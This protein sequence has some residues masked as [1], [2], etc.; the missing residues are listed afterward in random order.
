MFALLFAVALETVKFQAGQQELAYLHAPG[1]SAVLVVLPSQPESA[2]AEMKNWAPIAASR[3]WR[4]IMPQFP[5]A[6]DPGVKNLDAMV[7]DLRKRYSL[8]RT[9]VYLA[10][11]GA[12]SA[13][14]FYAAARAPYLWT[15]AMA[16]GGSPMPAIDSDRLFAANTLNTPVGWALTPEERTASAAIRQRLTTAGYNLT[17]LEAPTIGQVLDF[18]ARNTITGFPGKIDCETGN[19]AMAQCYWVRLTAFDPAL[20]NDAIRSSRVNPDLPASLDLGGFGYQPTAPGPGVLVEWLPPNYTGALRLKDRIVALSGKPVVDG[21]HYVELMKEVKEERPVS[22]TVER[23]TGKEKERFRLTTRY[24]LRQREEVITARV[25][26][27]FVPESREIVII[28]RAVA[29]LELTI[30]EGWAPSTVNWNGNQ[31]A[32]PQSP[33][34]LVLSLKEPGASRPCASQ[35]SP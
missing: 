33:G 8:A 18:L 28:S 35:V 17:V 4:L 2:E 25:Q 5:S 1:E 26:A 24:Q 32:S 29:A 16:I 21:G 3:K 27:E 23:V 9:P 13:A 7:A 10:G 30:P 19:P 31:M 20:R 6:A 14:V 12:A 15:A 11:G 34:C 22:I